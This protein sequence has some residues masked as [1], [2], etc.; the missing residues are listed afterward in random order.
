MDDKKK[1][2]RWIPGQRC[3]TSLCCWGEIICSDCRNLRSFVKDHMLQTAIPLDFNYVYHVASPLWSP[4]L[5]F[6]FQ[7]KPSEKKTLHKKNKNWTCYLNFFFTQYMWTMM[8]L[9]LICMLTEN[10]HFAH[11]IWLLLRWGKQSW[12]SLNCIELRIPRSW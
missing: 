6:H 1:P 11:D 7:Q 12:I 3:F 10:E 2:K 9:Q 8:K 4:L 5:S